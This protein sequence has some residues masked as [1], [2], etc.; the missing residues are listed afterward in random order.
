MICK[1]LVGLDGSTRAP[2]VFQ[3][4]VEIGAR[5]R[6]KVRPFRAVCIP[7]EFPAAAFGSLSDPLPAHLT[8]LALEDIARLTAGTVAGDVDPPIV[9]IGDPARLILEVCEE[10]D[11]D[12]VVIGSH[13]YW[14]LDRVLGTTAAHVAN[15]SKCNVLVVHERAGHWLVDGGERLPG[16]GT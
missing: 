2:G 5:F 7:P 16:A 10:L 11:V 1:I 6:A 14:G 3:A 15:K 9:R 13:G 12:L 8:K 4:A